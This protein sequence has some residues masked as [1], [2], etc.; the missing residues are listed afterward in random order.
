MRIDTEQ[1]RHQLSRELKPLYVVHGDE[2]LLALEAADRIRAAARAEGYAE[3]ELLTVEAGFKWASLAT[4]AGARSL[5][6]SK[7]LLEL[8]VPTGK[9]GVEGADTLQQY[10]RALPADTVTLVLLPRIDWRTLNSGWF[11]AL[12]H[13]GVAVEAKPVARKAL[14]QWLAGRLK[15]QDQHAE[16]AVLDFIADRV[17]GNLLA[18]YQEVQKLALLLPTGPVT[19]EQVRDAVIDVAR[20]DVFSLGEALLEGEPQKLV[21]MLD[22]LKREGAAPPLVLWAFAEEIRAI[23]KVITGIA[24]GR[25]LSLLWRDAKVRGQRHQNLMQQHAR[26]F[27]LPQTA[28]AL[29]HAAAIDRLIKGLGRGDVWDELLRLALRFARGN[30]GYRN[31]GSGVP[32]RA[33]GTGP[34]LF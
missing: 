31:S 5:F 22:G 4:A 16:A 1:L 20:Y 32:A 30:R 24:A 17:E 21:R 6:A 8:R 34:A 7:K 11:G 28:A 13:A 19:F 29:R 15:A 26:R 18:A 23:G 12:E 9:P 27:S 14:P 33:A 10:C 2:P 25:P 3:R